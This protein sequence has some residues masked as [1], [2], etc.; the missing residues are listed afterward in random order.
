MT[1]LG[2]VSITGIYRQVD[3]FAGIVGK[4]NQVE[5]VGEGEQNILQ[6]LAELKGLNGF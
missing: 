5:L 1:S 6:L 4:T 2:Q 3:E